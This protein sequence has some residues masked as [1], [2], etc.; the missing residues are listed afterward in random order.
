MRLR[1]NT[2]ANNPQL[3]E[4]FMESIESKVTPDNWVDYIHA[5]MRYFSMVKKGEYQY[6]MLMQGDMQDRLIQF[7]IYKKKNGIGANGIDNYINSL[8]QFYWV[9]GIKTID[10]ELVRKYRPE[11]VKKTRD[12]EYLEDE[13]F[14]IED[15]LDDRGKVCSGL[16]RGSGVRRGAEPILEVCDMFPR[17]TRFGKIYKILVYKGTSDEYTTACIPEIAARIDTYFEYRMLCGEVCKQFGKDHNHDYD[18]GEDATQRFFKSDERHLDP[19]APVIREQFDRNDS[20]AAKRPKRISYEQISDI[21]REA[22]IASGIRT[23]NKGEPYK[24]HTVMITHG[25]RKLFKKR[26]R[27]AK[28]DAIVLERLLG[29]TSGNSKDGVTK[30]MMTYDPED[31]EEMEQEFEKAIPHLT[32]SKDAKLQ[33]E[34]DRAKEELRNVPTVEKLQADLQKEKM[35][36]EQLYELLYKQGVIRK[37]NPI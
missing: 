10:W 16:M 4:R 15:K 33:A 28:V 11:R 7:V 37:E 12:R 21:I 13:V 29:H 14:K 1:A 23:V 31:W 27:Q 19:S 18:D 35:E 30:L 22:A 8:K 6:V 26:C 24:R 20:L 9:N 3:L 25:F 34:L 36:R 17:Q 5:Y 32:L 2:L